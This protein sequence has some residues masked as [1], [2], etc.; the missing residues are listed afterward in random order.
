M[1]LV[2]AI[3]ERGQQPAADFLH[4][5]VPEAAQRAMSFDLM[6]LVG[7]DLNDTTLAFTEHPFSEGF[8]VGDARIATHI[9]EGDCISNVYSIIHGPVTPCMSWA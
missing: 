8:A 4:A 6:K 5:R 2:H 9:Y 1:P 3:G 7:L